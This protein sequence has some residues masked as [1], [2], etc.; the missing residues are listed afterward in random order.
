MRRSLTGPALAAIAALALTFSSGCTDD[1]AGALEKVR[2]ASE[3]TLGA[4]TAEVAIT[5]ATDIGGTATTLT[6]DGSFDLGAGRGNLSLD[7]GSLLAGTKLDARILGDTAYITPPPFLAALVGKPFLEI[8]LALLV[9][10]NPQFGPISSTANPVTSVD[11]LRGATDAAV[12][13]PEVVRGEETTHFRGTLDLAAAG[14]EGDTNA[15][16]IGRLS[17]LLGT[18][19]VPY[20]VWLDDAGRIRRTKLE[21]T[22]SA[23]DSADGKASSTTVTTEL[24]GYGAAVEVT[25]PAKDQ[26]A[27]GNAL[28]KTLAGSG[29]S[30]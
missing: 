17:A 26:V 4:K 1:G 9:T 25:V 13:G 20:D 21:V 18:N 30:G 3:T 14:S 10:Q 28:L 12:V 16:A 5:V 24:F 8:D 23:A 15:E 29:A 27:D 22:K 11:A 19:E 2:A 6:G 7:L